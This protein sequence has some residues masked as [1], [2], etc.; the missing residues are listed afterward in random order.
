MES[1][2]NKSNILSP[3]SGFVGKNTIDDLYL[4][5][6]LRDLLIVKNNIN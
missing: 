6:F 5:L 2:E 3:L 4:K 1:N